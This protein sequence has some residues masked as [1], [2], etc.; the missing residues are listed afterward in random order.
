MKTKSLE[1]DVMIMELGFYQNYLFK[2]ISL[3]DQYIHKDST[4]RRYKITACTATAAVQ[5]PNEI[6]TNSQHPFLRTTTGVTW[7]CLLLTALRS[8]SWP[9]RKPSWLGPSFPSLDPLHHHRPSAYPMFLA[10]LAYASDC[11][12][13]GI[14]APPLGFQKPRHDM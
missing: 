10:E 13:P 6:N 9:R 12:Y 14:F 5:S 2:N 1:D 8:A 3:H 4:E 11:K 7:T